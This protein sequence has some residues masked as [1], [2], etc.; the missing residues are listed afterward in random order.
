MGKR[1]SSVPHLRD[2]EVYGVI[3]P[4][5]EGSVQRDS[6]GWENPPAKQYN[7]EIQQQ[8]Q[9]PPLRKQ[10]L[11]THRLVPIQNFERTERIGASEQGKDL[12]KKISFYNIIS[13]QANT[14][15]IPVDAKLPYRYGIAWSP[16]HPQSRGFDKRNTQNIAM[17]RVQQN[18]Q[19][20]DALDRLKQ[21]PPSDYQH[22]DQGHGN[23]EFD[24]F[25][26]H[27]KLPNYHYSRDDQE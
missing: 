5:Y 10:S 14:K 21:S 20:I 22:Y 16:D 15:E 19:H 8:Q 27:A 26:Q 24:Q 6:S 4:N 13:N 7:Y 3:S 11:S 25:Y 1:H 17:T 12:R 2:R 18:Y 23:N 9:F